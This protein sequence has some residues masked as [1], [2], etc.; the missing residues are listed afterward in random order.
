MAQLL[1]ISETIVKKN[2]NEVGDV[3]GVF[4]DSHRFSKTEI[5]KFDIR[6]IKGT[7]KEVTDKLQVDYPEKIDK[8][9]Q[10]NVYRT[11]GLEVDDGR[12]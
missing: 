7:R 1:L 9:Y 6:Q 8:K 5:E 3:V 4:E 2:V 11:L 10:Y 12:L